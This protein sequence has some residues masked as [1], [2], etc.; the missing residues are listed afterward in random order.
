MVGRPRIIEFACCAV[1]VG[2][3]VLALAVPRSARADQGGVSSYLPG[4]FGSLVAT[5]QE[6]GWSLATIYYHSTVSGGGEVAASRQATIGRF[7]RTVNIDLNANMKAG[8]DFQFVGLSYVFKQPVLGGQFALSMLGAYGYSSASIDGTLTLSSGNQTVTR[9]GSTGDARWGIADLFPQATLRWNQGV[10]NYMVYTM[11]N[12]PVGTY[13]A[14]RL[15]N[16]GL[17]YPFVDGG[18]GYT[19]RGLRR[20]VAELSSMLPR[21]D[22]A[23]LDDRVLISQFVPVALDRTC[24]F[25][26]AVARV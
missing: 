14:N 5:P 20:P 19:Y 17:G 4:S 16:F 3:T 25:A 1:V 6:P 26:N 7:S 18:V 12:L 9:S 11:G 8:V 15:V 10:N 23:M 22:R 13:D 24:E 21:N 2:N